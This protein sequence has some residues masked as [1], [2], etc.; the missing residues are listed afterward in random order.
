MNNTFCL[1]DAVICLC[2]SCCSE[3]KEQR[4]CWAK[5]RQKPSK[6]NSLWTE[7]T[8]AAFGLWAG[9]T[10]SYKTFIHLCNSFIS[11]L[12]FFVRLLV[13]LNENKRRK[14]ESNKIF[15]IVRPS[16]NSARVCK[17]ISRA[18]KIPNL[19]G[20]NQFFQLKLSKVG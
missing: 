2:S 19:L 8:N 20:K 3:L 15:R 18:Q 14:F 9:R 1:F 4:K 10:K 5:F 13:L 12:G 16:N 17:R 11:F 7:T 6:E